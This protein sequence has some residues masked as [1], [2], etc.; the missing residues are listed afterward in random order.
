M[1]VFSLMRYRF[2]ADRGGTRMRQIENSVVDRILLADNN[3]LSLLQGRP[4]SSEFLK[5]L[6]EPNIAFVVQR[7]FELDGERRCGDGVP[8]FGIQWRI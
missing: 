3:A 4:D 6:F 8:P 1:L 2:D 5:E 7:A